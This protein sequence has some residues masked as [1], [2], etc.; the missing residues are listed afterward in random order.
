MLLGLGTAALIVAVRRLTPSPLSLPAALAV[1][2]LL[3]VLL[4]PLPPT[5]SNDVLRY[6]WDGRVLLAG[7]NPY[8][9]APEAEAL[10]PLRDELWQGLHHRDV[11]TVYPPLAQGFFVAA[12]AL[13]GSARFQ[14]MALK[15]LLTAMDLA[16]CAG[17]VYLARRRGLPAA[18]ALWYAWN[19]VV[20]LEVAG[21]GHVDALGVAAVVATV[22][23]LERREPRAV[24]GAAA[25]AVAAVAAKLVPLVAIPMWTRQSHDR[26]RFG[27]LACGLLAALASAMLWSTGGMPPGVLRYGVAWE[28]N[29]P[30]FE[31]LWRVLELARSPRWVELGLDRL[32][33]ATGMHELFNRLYPFNYPQLHAKLVLGLLCVAAVLRSLRRRDPITGTGELLGTI[34]LCSATVYPWYA[35]WVL[36]WAALA[37]NRAWLALAALLPLSYLA[38]PGGLPLLPWIYLAIWAPFTLLLLRSRWTMR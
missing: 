37:G 8:R 33:A 25:S 22:A 28:F 6:V 11:P 19:P 30:L 24:F 3:R 16:A 21:M 17:L 20:A 9:L 35:L 4:L 31:P 14:V 5:L 2:G 34:L 26:R 15:L 38:Q 13:P 12:A 27:L 18:R 10:R 29:G 36:P 7:A 32:K 23:L 1:A